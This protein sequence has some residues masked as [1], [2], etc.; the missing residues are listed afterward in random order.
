MMYL[1]E[2]DVREASDG[3][4]VLRGRV[5]FRSAAR[6]AGANA[7]GVIMTGMGDDGARGL[8]EM[9]QAGAITFAQD[10]ATSI[11]F[12][13]PKEAIARGAADRVIPLGQIA[14]QMLA[15]ANR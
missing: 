15:A 4:A 8:L 7:V 3:D 13:M 9:K 5:L 2:V 6:A 11:V 12:G 10:E 14:R 1:C